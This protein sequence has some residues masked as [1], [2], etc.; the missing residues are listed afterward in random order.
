[1]TDN[2]VKQIGRTIEERGNTRKMLLVL[3]RSHTIINYSSNYPKITEA[4]ALERAT[5]FI[6]AAYKAL[7]IA[8]PKKEA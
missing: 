7:G 3:I 6:M 8:I 4:D 5:N 1:M 2:L